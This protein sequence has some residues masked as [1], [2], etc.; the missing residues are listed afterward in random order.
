LAISTPSNARRAFTRIAMSN[1]NQDL[2]KLTIDGTFNLMTKMF[3]PLIAWPGEIGFVFVMDIND[4]KIALDKIKK[5]K[6]TDLDVDS[7]SSFNFMQLL[8]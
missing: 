3:V 2:A 7:L 5:C 6:Y 4:D 1:T 8:I